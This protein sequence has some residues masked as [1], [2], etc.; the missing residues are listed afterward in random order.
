M[1][2]PTVSIVTP[3]YN[4][5]TF[6][7]EAISSV[8]AQTFGDFEYVICDNHSKDAS[9]AIAAR[10]AQKD[11]RVRVINPP[12]F[13]PQAQN[14]NFALQHISAHAKYCKMI[15]ADDRLFPNC[16]AEMVALAERAPNVG[17]ISCYRLIETSPDGFGLRPERDVF[18]GREAAR[19]HLLGDAL[20]FGNPTQV[21][22]R[23]DIVRER[24][25]EFYSPRLLNFDMDVAYR[26]LEKYDFGFVHQILCFARYQKD[27]ITPRLNGLNYWF[28]S[29]YMEV[30][31][32][33]KQ[34]LS[35][36]E[37]AACLER[38]RSEFY[39]ELGKAWLKDRV[40]FK[41][42]D[43]FWKFQAEQL[44]TVGQTIEQ[45]RLVRGV[46]DAMF[47]YVG[48]LGAAFN[49]ARYKVSPR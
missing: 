20:A 44:Q 45:R 23:A 32:N 14:F 28:L 21:M 42:P 39:R 3:V 5:E 46:A 34:F 49:T 31:D 33:G 12:T 36:T 4:G 11:A 48:N 8:L 30:V 9:G 26:I 7:E 2:S 15:F 19:A 10:Y 18:T 29:R 1:T 13:L 35:D 27:A 40:R 47:S 38:V 24:L 37:F 25:P 6:L 16:V 17:I 41:S 22:Y 43:E